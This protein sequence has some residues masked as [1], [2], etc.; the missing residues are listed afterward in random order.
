MNKLLTDTCQCGCNP[1]LP[2]NLLKITSGN[3]FSIKLQLTEK[4][5]DNWVHYD[6]T[7]MSNVTVS[8]VSP[9]NTATELDYIID[10]AGNIQA[11][12]D[13]QKFQSYIIYGVEVLWRDETDVVHVDKRAYAPNVFAFVNS[14]ME[15]TDSS[16]EYTSD[17][18]Y[19]YNI[20][21]SNDV[22][23]LSI[24]YIPEFDPAEYYTRDNIDSKLEDYVTEQDLSDTLEN[25]ATDQDLADAIATIDTSNYVTNSSLATTLQDYE[26]KSELS[27]TLQDYV[28]DSE[29]TTALN[30]YATK[31]YV[32]D[33]LDDIDIDTTNFYTKSDIDTTLTSYA[34]SISSPG[35]LITG[36]EPNYMWSYQIKLEHNG[37]E[38]NR[39]RIPAHT[40]SKN[41]DD[42]WYT[43]FYSAL[44]KNN[45]Y[46]AFLN[47]LDTLSEISSDYVT[48]TSLSTTLQDYVTDTELTTTLNPYATQQY[49]DNAV[50]QIDTS[51]YYTKSQIDTTL[52]SYVKTSV[53]SDYVT[54][55]SLNTTLA[56]YVTNT[57]LAT[58][59]QDY[60]TDTKLSTEL[61]PIESDITSLDGRVTTLENNPSV[62]SNVVTSDD[63]N[64]IVCLTQS[65]YDTL[66]QN[67]QLDSDVFYYITD[68][69]SNYVTN[70]SLT[71]TLANY[72]TKNYVDT[73]VSQVQPDTTNLVTINTTQ[74]ISGAKTFTAA[75]TF[76]GNNKFTNETQFTATGS[77][78][79]N[80]FVWIDTGLYKSS[81]F[82]RPEVD[83][84][85][86]GQVLLP[87]VT[88]SNNASSFDVTQN[89]ITFNKITS[90]TNP[91]Q[92]VLQQVAK[93]DDIGIYEGTTL[94]SNKYLQIANMPTIPSATSDLTNDSG[95]VSSS[96]ITT[97]L[98]IS[99]SDYD[100]LV[101]NSQVDA[102]TLYIIV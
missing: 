75:N 47:G 13:A 36:G 8:V 82:T 49:V 43:P 70:S 61:S 55:T 27:T 80:N 4:I 53:L 16:Y 92:P 48:N 76:S 30:P 9:N 15:A 93:I 73:A 77:G 28:T 26:T 88:S 24:G 25:Y 44:L 58:T 22:V 40:K 71:T 100:T 39:V 98:Q 7:D 89:T 32:D 68:A 19:E 10:V 96:S 101:N 23:C 59:L 18:P 41:S 94:L 21:M 90:I 102:N 79:L 2:E 37:T 17:N 56:N 29:L 74:T 97:I 84:L 86:V 65:E 66:E 34:T 72:A 20:S 81:L 31:Q 52:Q 87:Q 3:D 60:V 12:V 99:Q 6:M 51:N 78:H 33:A 57:S 54:N 64:E 62:P 1:T 35:W 5:D 45:D 50:A 69:T 83:Q 67:D 95:F 63:G 42:Q 91:S 14:S 46:I 11:I 38:L 85:I